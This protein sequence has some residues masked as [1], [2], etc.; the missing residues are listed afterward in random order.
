MGSPRKTALAAGRVLHRCG[1][2]VDGSSCPVPDRSARPAPY[3]HRVCGTKSALGGQPDSRWATW[4]DGLSLTNQSD[5]TTIIC[6]PA[7][8]Q[9]APHGLLQ[10]VR[11]L[12][13]PLLSVTQVRPGQPE[14]PPS[15]PD[16]S[17]IQPR[18]PT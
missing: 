10:K 6:G 14:S 9:A 5:G 15:S 13:L 4:F 8:G 17:S 1:C 12:G 7:A 18:R 2:R 11:D 16:N 3:H